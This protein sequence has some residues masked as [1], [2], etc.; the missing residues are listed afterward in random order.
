MGE[1]D[2]LAGLVPLCTRCVS[3]LF[4]P[5]I[6]KMAMATPNQFI[7]SE[8][9]GQFLHANKGFRRVLD[10][11]TH[12]L[13]GLVVTGIRLVNDHGGVVVVRCADCSHRTR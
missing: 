7:R 6:K 5:K 2:A 10:V 11:T 9:L 1:G 4:F 8:A 3:C 12:I 13:C